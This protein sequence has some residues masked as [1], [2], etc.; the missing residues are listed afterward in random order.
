[1]KPRYSLSRL[2]TA[3]L[4]S[5]VLAPAALAGSLVPS[6]PLVGDGY[7]SARLLVLT[8]IPGAKLK[9]KPERG[10]VGT[11][12]PVDGG[13][14]VDYLPPLVSDATSFGLTVTI[15]A[16][17]YKEVV[18]A[19][20]D[21]VPGFTSGFELEFGAEVVAPGQTASVKVRPTGRTPQ[22]DS[23][24]RPLIRVSQGEVTAL[25][26]SGDGTWVA[27]YTPPAE[28]DR[29]FQAAFFTADAAAPDRVQG[30]AALPVTMRQSVTFDAPPDSNNILLV[31]GEEFGPIKASPAG[32]VAFELP[33]HPAHAEGTLR[34]VTPDGQRSDSSVPLPVEVL[35]SLVL[36]PLPDSAPAGH[37]VPVFVYG[38][39]GDGS[40]MDAEQISF[41]STKGQVTG[42]ELVSDGLG[43]TTWTLPSEGESTL[44]AAHGESSTA[45]TMTTL[46]GHVTLGL[47]SDPT[48][49]EGK[50]REFS[51]TARVKDNKG[52]AL[53]GRMPR[54]TVE[55][56]A[57]VGKPLDNEDGTYT[58]K[59]KRDYKAEWAR[60][61]A[62]PDLQPTGLPPARLVVFPVQPTVQ[63]NGNDT[64]D[65]IVVAEDAMGMPVPGVDLTL[66]VPRG[67]GSL[68]P[69]GSTGEHGVARIPYRA[70]I[71]PGVITVSVS[72]AGLRSDTILWQGGQGIPRP[73]LVATGS[74]P[75]LEALERW[76]GAFPAVTIG[77]QDPDEAP[78][79]AEPTAPPGLTMPG[80]FAAGP[81]VPAT[82]QPATQNPPG[83]QPPAYQAPGRQRSSQQPT[84]RQ[85]TSKPGMITPTSQHKRARLRAGLADTPFSYAAEVDGE[86]E[87][88][89]PR[90]SFAVSPWFGAVGIDPQAQVWF[91]QSKEWG[92]DVSA[93][94]GVYSVR[95]GDDAYFDLPL[96]IQAGARY[97]F[98]DSGGIFSAYGGLSFQY[99]TAMI[100]AYS[101]QAKTAA[102]LVTYPIIGG[103]LAA[104]MMF[105]RNDLLVE[106]ELAETL[107]PWPVVSRA[108]VVVD[109]PLGTSPICLYAGTAFEYRSLRFQVDD[110][111][112]KMGVKQTGGEIRVGIT[113]PID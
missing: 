84:G 68:P 90:A 86:A 24:R 79:P 98:F 75:N 61:T 91:G 14:A 37:S 39:Q 106:V 88:Y 33:L 81:T 64:V 41:H 10:R 40:P 101:N 13:Y 1:M 100:F 83:Y 107:A 6:P 19:R 72:G 113:L 85:R 9:V 67:D 56:A 2:I 54:I 27:R 74:K 45:H 50:A 89:A 28:I 80:S 17:G 25:V 69:K 93:R 112:A 23:E 58:W 46:G 30:L 21:V 76:K 94:V 57:P 34:S 108:D 48:W 15:K 92:A 78:P 77:N 60:V 105:E 82:P 12:T 11:V 43:R 110:G 42:L 51:I 44:T 18:E 4:V 31:A 29:P 8:D 71:S 7:T 52:T 32:K 103:R 36:S 53:V 66:A 104:G 47:S 99:V 96:D 95:V 26:P 22:Q 102:E 16:P 20:V 49:L 70:G 59:Y 73:N 65:L 55:N 97:R 5:A 111:D 109:I 63:G 38:V 87:D 62:W 3:A 35:P